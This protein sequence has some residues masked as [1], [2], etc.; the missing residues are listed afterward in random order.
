MITRMYADILFD[1]EIDEDKHY[2]SPGGYEVRDKNGNTL[3]FDFEDCCSWVDDENPCL[4]HILQRNLDLATF[5]EAKDLSFFLENLDKFTDFYIYTG[6]YDEPEIK[7]L[8]IINVMFEDYHNEKN[9]YIDDSC[10]TD[11]LD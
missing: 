1:R 11:V 4:L 3:Q 7:P 10:L 9:Y 8:K 2:I 5:P 6:E